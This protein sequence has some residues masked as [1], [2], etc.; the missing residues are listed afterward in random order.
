MILSLLALATGVEASEHRGLGE[1]R[2]RGHLRVCGD[3]ANLP[4][5]SSDPSTPG[6]EV[7][8]AGL[9]AREIGVDARFQWTPTHRQALRPLRDGS[10]DLFMGL[11]R[12]ERFTETNPWIT[13]SRPY[14]TMGHA[15]LAKTG[16]GIRAMADLAGRRVAIEGTSVADFFLFD[17]GMVRGIYR[18]Q[19]AAVR[20][21]S[22]GEAP[23][24][25]LWLPV[26][27]WLARGAPDLRVIPLSDPRLEFPI[28]AGVRRRDADLATAVDSAIG[29]LRDSGKVQEILARYGAMASPT[30]RW[31]SSWLIPVQARDPVENGRSLFLTACSRCHG[32]E[33]VGGGQGGAVPPIKN[34]QGGQEKFVRIVQNGRAGTPMGPFKGILAVDEILNIY[35]YLNSS[36]QQ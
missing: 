2:Q 22:A 15:L 3:P 13:V 16:S 29:R 32:A 10:C 5:S 27:A 21:V 14:Y 25:L 6:F 33:G 17:Q 18:S 20:G 30:G 7:E 9:L 4:F 1:V 24:A 31:R 11:P 28:G 34:Y 35:A 8:L 12:D 19:E 23:A 36:R 26:A